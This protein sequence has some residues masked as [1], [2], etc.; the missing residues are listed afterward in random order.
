METRNTLRRRPGALSLALSLTLAL[1]SAPLLT[2]CGGGAADPGQLSN[3]GYAAL[4]SGDHAGAVEN[5]E[6]ALAGLEVGTPEY[7]RAK[8]GEIEALIHLDAN[9]ATEQLMA[10]GDNANEALVATIGSKMTAAKEFA[11]AVAV[12]D[13]G[14]KRFPESTKIKAMLDKVQAEAEKAGDSGALDALKG[15]GYL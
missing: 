4:G 15:L 6:A 3:E 14:M 11:A 5:F 9:R 2:A 13:A 1:A 7:M 10:L 8:A 12:L